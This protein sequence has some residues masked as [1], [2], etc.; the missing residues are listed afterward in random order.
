MACVR[1][2][3]NQYGSTELSHFFKVTA[4]QLQYWDES[5]FIRPRHER[6]LRL[7][8]P[9]QALVV[10]MAMAFL[11][12]GVTLPR[13][14]RI[15]PKPDDL[16]QRISALFETEQQPA[17][18]VTTTGKRLTLTPA[19]RLVSVAIKATG[20]V[21]AVDLDAIRRTLGQKRAA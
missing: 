2:L 7:Y 5:G 17:A 11:N 6:H 16:G 15:M 9:E 12:K 21:V 4:R 14:R 19:D 3:H 20:G 13:L 1:S 8:S 18:V 10:G